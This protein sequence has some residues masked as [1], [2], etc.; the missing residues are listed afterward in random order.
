VKVVADLD[1]CVGSG[2]CTFTAPDVFDQDEADGRV[3]V[4]MA[5]LAPDQLDLVRQAVESCPAAAL[6]LLEEPARD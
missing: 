5:E 6:S 4:R 1:L 3:I 2:M